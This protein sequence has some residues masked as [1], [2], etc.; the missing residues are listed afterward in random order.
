MLGA[1][2]VALAQSGCAGT[3]FGRAGI[4][5]DMPGLSLVELGLHL[6]ALEPPENLQKPR[7]AIEKIMFFAVWGKLRF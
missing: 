5:L 2:V 3:R 1:N 4:S 6:D 7:K